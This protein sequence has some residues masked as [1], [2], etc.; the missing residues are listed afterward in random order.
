MAALRLRGLYAV[1]PDTADSAGLVAK[2]RDAISGGAVVVQYRSKL[3]DALL[4]R[5]Q[6]EMLLDVCRNS[7]VP[8]VVNDDLAM[9]LRI[10]A[11]GVHLGHEDVA[12]LAARGQAQQGFI[13]GASCYDDLGLALAAA[14]DGAS[15]L[16][17][18]AAFPSRTKPGAVHAT[19][20]LFERARQ[21]FTL[22]IAAIGGITLDNASALLDA[23]ADL[24]AVISDLFDS[25]DVAARAAAYAALFR[26]FVPSAGA[27][28]SASG[29]GV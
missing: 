8:L 14:R 23:G 1:T 9:A 25:T 27:S 18:G 11:D 15:Y 22:P 29:S 3:S 28:S 21:Q 7:G 24:L 19:R 26:R 6:A 20:A 2:V 4:R 5:V 16:A 17:F 10:G 13:V 12:P